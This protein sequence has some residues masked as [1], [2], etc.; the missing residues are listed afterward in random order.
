MTSMPATSLDV[1]VEGNVFHS[2]HERLRGFA[3]H[4]FGSDMFR[5][6]HVYNIWITLE[7]D[8]ST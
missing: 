8:A 4:G 6:K 1:R 2:T 7:R 3:T 5:N